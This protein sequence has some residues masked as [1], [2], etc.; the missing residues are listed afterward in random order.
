LALARLLV[1][2]SPGFGIGRD[3]VDA[4]GLRGRKIAREAGL[5]FGGIT[6]QFFV[7][8]DREGNIVR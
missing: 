2:I 4:F 5:R 6:P 3:S 7:R 8:T 1:T